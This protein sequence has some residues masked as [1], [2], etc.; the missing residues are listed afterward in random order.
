MNRRQKKKIFERNY[1]SIMYCS[2]YVDYKSIRE[3]ERYYH[4]YC[5]RWER[6]NGTYDNRKIKW[7]TIRKVKI[8]RWKRCGKRAK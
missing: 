8:E 5:I 7:R 4:E 3:W 1:R 6:E 2:F